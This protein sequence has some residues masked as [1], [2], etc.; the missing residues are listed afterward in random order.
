MMSPLPT[1]CPSRHRSSYTTW[2]VSPSRTSATKSMSYLKMLAMP[3]IAPGV[4][5]ARAP[6]RYSELEMV[7][8]A[9]STRRSIGRSW[10]FSSMRSPS[11]FRSIRLPAS[12]SKRRVLSW[13]SPSISKASSWPSRNW[14][15]AER[16]EVSSSSRCISLAGSFICSK[17]MPRVSPLRT[18]TNCQPERVATPSS[19]AFGSG[20]ASEMRAGGAT[21]GA[22]RDCATPGTMAIRPAA[23][24]PYR[25]ASSRR[26]CDDLRADSVGG[27]FKQGSANRPAGSG[28]GTITRLKYVRQTLVEAG[29]FGP[30]IN[31]QLTS[32]ARKRA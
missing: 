16:A 24:T 26:S 11:T 31:S 13:P 2:K 1:R 12:L 3:L 19:R 32:R 15:S 20:S 14:T 6:S 8:A 17:T 9:I 7:P 23:M 28:R 29:F 22:R 18:R 5:P 25:P 10:T 21:C 27:W 4:S 30:A